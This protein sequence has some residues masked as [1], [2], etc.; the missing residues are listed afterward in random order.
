MHWLF[1]SHSLSPWQFTANN[2]NN[3]ATC[4]HTAIQKKFMKT[5]MELV[6]KTCI[7][8]K[9]HLQFFIEVFAFL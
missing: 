3:A 5:M 8:F 1:L 4:R 6:R 2:Y 9:I 7:L